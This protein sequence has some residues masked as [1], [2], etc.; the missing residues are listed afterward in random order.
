MVYVYLVASVIFAAADAW[1]IHHYK[2]PRWWSE[3][4]IANH[5]RSQL[6]P[7]AVCAAS[8]SAGGR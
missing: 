7:S 2:L 6:A 5:E 3:P 1:L 8:N 4:L